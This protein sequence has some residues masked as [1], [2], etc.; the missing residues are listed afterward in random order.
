MFPRSTTFFCL[1]A[2]IVGCWFAY[3]P[4]YS[5]EPAS[6]SAA[7]VDFNRDVRP[8]L[9]NKCFQ[10]HGPDAE[11]RESDLR[12]DS[13]GEAKA[14]LDG[15][16]AIVAFHPE[17]S[18]LVARI[19]SQDDD[20]RMPPADSGKSLS[21]SEVE[22][23]TDWIAQGAVWSQHW[24]LVPLTKHSL[25]K[26]KD[27]DWPQNAID[28]FVLAQLEAKQL[29]PSH[30]ANRITL[31]RRLSFD[32]TGLPPTPEEVDRFLNNQDP[33]A[34]LKETHR[35]LAAPQHGQR[36]ARFW[37][38]LARYTDV[39]ASWLKDAHQAWMY[40]DWVVNAMNA[41]MPYDRFVRLQLAADG[42]PDATVEDLA[43]LGFLGLSP[44]YW[45]ELQLAPEV[46]MRVVAD[47]WDERID[48]VSRTFLGLTV[49]C[50]RCH[51]HKFDPITSEDYY[52][53]AGVFA[54]SQLA[55]R[56]L[57]PE[58]EAMQVRAAREQVADLE[59]KLKKLEKQD[60]PEAISLKEELAKLRATPHF[61]MPFAHIV[62]DASIYVV[63]DG[64]DRTKLEYRKGEARELPIFQRGNP[65]STGPAVT[66]R[67]L[68][69]LSERNPTPLQ[70]GSGRGDLALA[71]FD[72]SG[73]LAAR[74]IVNR[75]W[76]QHFGQ[77]L[78]RTPSDF[79]L[80]GE[81]PSHPVLLDYLSQELIRN[82]WSLKWLHREIV[83]SATYQQSSE[84][85]QAAHDID[86]E[87]RL[88]WRANRRRLDI[89]M[90]RDA[91][92]TVAGNLDLKFGGAAEPLDDLSF[93]R[94]TLYGTISRDELNQVL[95]LYDFPEATT[96][97]PHRVNTTTPLQQLF[98]LNSAFLDRQAN[99]VSSRL[100]ALNG[101]RE[102]VDWLYRLLFSR[103]AT[104][105][106]LELG[107]AYIKES[108]EAIDA[109]TA[110]RDYVHALL[111]LNEF[112]FVD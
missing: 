63:P 30:P 2:G 29:Q 68:A 53:L 31:L 35:L 59:A 83:T 67:F 45:K 71:L 69:A 7:K 62:E 26:V 110:W 23:L 14:D 88:L 32:L 99:A 75:V 21:K 87:N 98:V 37:L 89:E 43:A 52:A 66:R 81:Y 33:A 80:Q 48:T 24:S 12:L 15:H 51:D 109:S 91:M 77:G 5:D 54:S 44:T 13:E 38:D 84:F 107:L 70:T 18:D 90:W 9:S 11:K 50:A 4:V 97:S 65:D 22:L 108:T 82:G 85:R 16:K 8:I 105:T 58:A 111:G 27:R 104:D 25:P 93:N 103:A 41:D 17:Q 49:S 10:C 60:S 92:L 74:V 20:Q 34:Y 42:Q 6:R 86:P 101:D 55:D 72:N 28:Y 61:E 76:E 56:P 46:I 47:E 95:R 3:S 1:L 79:G 36:W 100:S 19:T 78:V 96:H 40:R 73:H 94:R 57:L 112:L 39:T 64:P 106:E 102:K